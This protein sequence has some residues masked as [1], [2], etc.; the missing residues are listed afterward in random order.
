MSRM[1]E[2]L[3]VRTRLPRPGERERID[4]HV[5]DVTMD[6]ETLVVSLDPHVAFLGESAVASFGKFRF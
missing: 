1:T 6:Q 4:A 5:N 2:F 3:C